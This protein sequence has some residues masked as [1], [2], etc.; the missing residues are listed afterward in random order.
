MIFRRAV[1]GAGFFCALVVA[2]VYVN[3]LGDTD[4]AA[5]AQDW[6]KPAEQNTS[7]KRLPQESVEAKED[8][9]APVVAIEASVSEDPEAE[10]DED[11]VINTGEYLSVTVPFDDGRAAMNVGVLLDVD[12]VLASSEE[13]MNVGPDIESVNEIV[14][15]SAEPLNEGAFLEAPDVAVF[16]DEPP[17]NVGEFKTVSDI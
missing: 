3:R 11:T 10:S 15:T 6:G 17:R 13:V 2:G 16:S 8:R 12:S 14:Q 4:A 9:L 5:V 7:E 1:L